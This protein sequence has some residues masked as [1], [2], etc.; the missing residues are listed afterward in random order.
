MVFSILFLLYRYIHSDCTYGKLAQPPYPDLGSDIPSPVLL[1][2]T[3]RNFSPKP[4][5]PSPAPPAPYPFLSSADKD[6]SAPCRQPQENH[7]FFLLDLPATLNAMATA[8]FCGFPS[9]ISVLIFSLIVSFDDP[10]FNGINYPPE[11]LLCSCVPHD[12]PAI[13]ATIPA[14]LLRS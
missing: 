6:R 10:F 2:F 13:T 11:F 3:F 7:F 8:C 9:A 4:P 5:L 12:L 14:S 1:A